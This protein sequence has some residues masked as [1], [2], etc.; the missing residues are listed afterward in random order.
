VPL[1]TAGEAA[2]VKPTMTVPVSVERNFYGRNVQVPGPIALQSGAGFVGAEQLVP[3]PTGRTGAAVASAGTSATV[4][5]QADFLTGRQ[6]TDLGHSAPN[7]PFQTGTDGLVFTTTAPLVSVGTGVGVGAWRAASTPVDTSGPGMAGFVPHAVSGL[8]NRGYGPTAFSSAVPNAPGRA[9][10]V[11][12]FPDPGGA[13]QGVAGLARGTRPVIG[14]RIPGPPGGG[15]PPPGGPGAGTGTASGGQRRKVLMKLETYD[16]SGSL[17][18]FLAKFSK[19]AE[20]MQ[21]TDTDRYYH[22]CASLNGIAGQVLWDA[23][24]QATVTDVIGL[25]RTR[26]GNEL[27]AERFK[28]ELKVR[29]RRTGESLQQLYQDISKLVVLAHP[30]EGPALVN[31][32]AKE[33]FVIALGDPTLQL[34]VIEREPK[35]VEDAL[36]IAV[37]M[38]AYQASVV[39]PEPD[40][41]AADHKVKHKVK[42]TYAVEGTEQVVPAGE[43]DMMLI[44]KRLSELQAVCN[45]TREEIG[46]VKA[47]KEEAEKKAAQ[48]AQSAKA[49]A[50]A[51]KSANPPAAA[52]ST[53]NPNGNS[54]G[55]QPQ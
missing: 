4:S 52:G 25:L 35:T 27:Q 48:A 43:D 15:A 10:P 9:I 33:A 45:S 14:S 26:F 16:G 38:E 49:A 19:L 2:Y 54:S 42:S 31:H 36:N 29:R 6:S 44:H 3:V 1:G 34:K 47:Q 32:V 24:P 17:E 28:A 40:K 41:G 39:S 5:V 46:R 22:L 30:N 50:Q 21:W 20:Y 8:V 51:A 12:G 7:R 55:F 18:T 23:G 53:P 37:K 13:P 11:A